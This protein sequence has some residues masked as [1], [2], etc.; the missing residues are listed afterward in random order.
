MADDLQLLA[1]FLTESDGFSH[2]LDE[3]SKKTPKNSKPTP[4]QE[5]SLSTKEKSVV[6]ENAL[7]SS[8]DEYG[9]SNRVIVQDLKKKVSN[10]N[11]VR[12][13][14][15]VTKS[16]NQ[17]VK[18]SSD[19]PKPLPKFGSSPS[20]LNV[21]VDPIFRMRLV[22]PL[23]SSATLLE[24]AKG[25]T[26]VPIHELNRYLLTKDFDKV[27]WFTAGIIVSRYSKASSKGTLY[28]IL[29]LSDLHSGLKSFS[30]FLF[31]KCH[32]DLSKIGIATAIGILNPSPLDNRNNKE[33]AALS[34]RSPD[35]VIVWGTSKDY[36]T[37]KTVKKDGEVCGA[38]VNV[39]TCRTCIYHL[40]TEYKKFSQRIP[41]SFSKVEKPSRNAKK[42]MF[43]NQSVSLQPAKKN[44][45]MRAKDL[46]RINS[47]TNS[48][49]SKPLSSVE[50]TS[51]K[52]DEEPQPSF[53]EHR[54]AKMAQNSVSTNK[55]EPQT[56]SRLFTKNKMPVSS[57]SVSSKPSVS[58]SL[59]GTTKGSNKSNQP[60]KIC[61]TSFDKPV[62]KLSKPSSLANDSIDLEN[63]V[64]PSAS[65][66]KS[67]SYEDFLALKKSKNSRPAEDVC[68]TP[69]TKKVKVTSASGTR[70]IVEKK[71]DVELNFS[72]DP[73]ISLLNRQTD[74]NSLAAKTPPTTSSGIAS[75]LLSAVQNRLPK[76]A[77]EKA[78]EK[79][80]QYVKKHG[81]LPNAA[82][83]PKPR[84]SLEQFKEEETKPKVETGTK[85]AEFERLLNMKSRNS[86]LVEAADSAAQEEYFD[87]LEKKEQLEN[88]MTTTFKLETK[89]YV[90]YDCKY[91][92]Y[93]LSE[94]CFKEK[95]K[96]KC[97]TTNKRFFM[98]GSCKLKKTIL[99]KIP[100]GACERC[101]AY[102]W[103]RAAMMSERKVELPVPKLSIR[104]DEEA[105]YGNAV[106]G[107]L[108]L[109]VPDEE[110]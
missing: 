23:F 93:T 10:S 109:L 68:E 54:L 103:E 100:N 51:K 34:I 20:D 50:N 42:G 107:N 108:N 82:I 47:L 61:D 75:Q 30:L 99:D 106:A 89:A 43:F 77:R 28:T 5:K 31:G 9:E 102:Q 64:K 57:P 11:P 83:T 56:F 74:P 101:G 36:G 62:P 92:W 29:T 18:D 73:E 44:L 110:K 79:A 59:N 35:Q 76:N 25:R 66:Q 15:D 60:G 71:V 8:D 16:W 87:K 1:K 95:H 12:T 84:K 86:K 45:A 21:F 22:N 98:C 52:R 4:K 7:D 24:R 40:N 17:K 37:C 96:T 14:N 69:P 88:K 41:S 33:E 67:F 2:S 53:F 104:G 48:D 13:K 27:D 46:A 6:H 3:S 55:G 72:F 70:P 91:T 80:L 39:N 85:S 65:N 58:S 32:T 78:K 105:H 63:V 94:R 19:T 26:P 38:F 81:P 90:C 49:P 97:I